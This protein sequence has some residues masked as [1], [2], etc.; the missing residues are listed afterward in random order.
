MD[1]VFRNN[2]AWNRGRHFGD[3][4]TQVFSPLGPTST[5]DHWENL[6]FEG[7]GEAPQLK[8]LD[9]CTVPYGSTP[10]NILQCRLIVPTTSRSPSPLAFPIPE[11]RR[12]LID[13][14]ISFRTRPVGMHVLSSKSC[15]ID[16][17]RVEVLQIACLFRNGLM[18]TSSRSV[19]FSR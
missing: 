4:R 3:M 6:E 10:T 17:T 5:S 12:R 8:M 13:A 19:Q 14:G 7:L 16:V 11:L 1:A 9:A 2:N 18:G 15:H